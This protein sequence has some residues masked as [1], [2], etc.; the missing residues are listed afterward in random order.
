M[1]LEMAGFPSVFLMDKIIF[2]CTCVLGW[3]KVSFWYFHKMLQESLSRPFGQPST[4]F[5]FFS[6]LLYG[7]LVVVLGISLWQGGSPVLEQKLY[8]TRA[9]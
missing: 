4:L 8:R 9:Q 6:S 7:S 3:P 2:H 1:L 5:L